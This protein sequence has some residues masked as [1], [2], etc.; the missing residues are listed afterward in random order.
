MRWVRHV[1]HME[2]R[3]G[4]YWIVV[5]KTEGERTLQRLRHRWDNNIIVDLWEIGWNGHGLALAGCIQ[6]KWWAAVN[7]VICVWVSLNTGS[8]LTKRGTVSF[9]RT[10]TSGVSY[11]DCRY[12]LKESIMTM[13]TYIHTYIHEYIHTYIHTY[14]S[15]YIRTLHG[16]LRMSQRQ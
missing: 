1:V 8:L 15:T 5:G 16:F 7:T 4:A 12:H 3:R 11:L 14:L 10:L 6:G 13:H 9:S 2:N